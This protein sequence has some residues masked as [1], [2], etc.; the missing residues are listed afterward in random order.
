ML[1]DVGGTFGPF[2]VDERHWVESR[3]WADAG[4]CL[5][6]LGHSDGS[7]EAIPISEPGRLLLADK[8]RQLSEAQI[9][10]IFKSADFPDPATGEMN[11]RVTLWVKAFEDKV[12][13]IAD[14]PACPAIKK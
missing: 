5:V 14:R 13:Q 10:T 9:L 3:I 6:A 8:L 7:T 4:Q 1:Q 2:S 11:G 12:R